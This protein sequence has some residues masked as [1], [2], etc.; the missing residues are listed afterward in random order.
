MAVRRGTIEGLFI[1]E[2]PTFG[3]ERGFFRESFRLN[4]LEEAIGRPISLVQENHSRS[5]RGALRGL[6]A[7]DWE[8]L[9]YVPR[10]EVFTAIA[11]VRPASP[12]FGQVE[13]FVLGESNRLK[14]FLPPA[15]AHGFCVLSDVADYV[16]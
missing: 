3:D 15:V 16:Y 11:D 10:G 12:T 14:L 6:H 7:E 2:R 4:E 13:T 8:K 5:R 9:I 1:I